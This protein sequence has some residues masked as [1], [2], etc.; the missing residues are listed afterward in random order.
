M[1]AIVEEQGADKRGLA[2]G[3]SFGVNGLGVA[4]MLLVFGS[5]GGL[6]GIEIGVAGGTAVLAQKV[7]EA[8]FGDDAVRQLA[9][10][11]SERLTQ[12]LG[13]LLEADASIAL[14]AVT[15]LA[16]STSAGDELRHAAAE[17]ERASAEERAARVV[18]APRGSTPV[19]A[20]RGAHLRTV[21]VAARAIPT[22][23]GDAT[24]P[25]PVK[26]SK[27]KPG[28]WQRLLGWDG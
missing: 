1:L 24:T 17:L 25:A 9:S 22:A 5:T 4:L 6:T 8:V 3:L 21:D 13:S 10:E 19:P 15:A 26:E 28:F 12:R 20:L 14:T 16:V 18:H 7:L 27:K 11:A 23:G 2:R